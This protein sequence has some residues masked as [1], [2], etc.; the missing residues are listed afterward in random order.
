MREL[1]KK[2][3][4]LKVLALGNLGMLINDIMHWTTGEFSG[5]LDGGAKAAQLAQLRTGPPVTG[6]VQFG[7]F[8]KRK[9]AAEVGESKLAEKG[10][11]KR[12]LKRGL[13][14]LAEKGVEQVRHEV[15]AV[16]E[17]QETGNPGISSLM[18]MQSV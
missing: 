6:L 12:G 13:S 11:F 1:A 8:R 14:K 7:S 10:V 15:E 17:S 5:V 3:P 2:G 4:I 18:E 16:D 9:R